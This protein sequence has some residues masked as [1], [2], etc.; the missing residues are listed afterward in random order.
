[1]AGPR[2]HKKSGECRVAL[3]SELVIGGAPEL[4]AQL[5]EA[6]AHP[7]PVILDAMAVA[8]LDTAGLQLLAAFVEARNETLADWHWE[9]VGTALRECA[10]QLGMERMLELPDAA[11]AND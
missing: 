10:A 9:N 7:E 4:Y 2:K 11:P 6:L 5:G 8:R 1:M 3:G